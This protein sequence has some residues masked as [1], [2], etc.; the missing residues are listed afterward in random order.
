MS[1]AQLFNHASRGR[2]VGEVAAGYP[3]YAGV[4]EAVFDNGLGGLGGEAAPPVRFT[5]P[6]A[7]LR[8]PMIG[9]ERVAG[10]AGQFARMC[11]AKYLL[12]GF[13][14]INP[15]IRGVHRIRVWHAGRHAGDVPITTEYGDTGCV[16][17]C[18]LAQNEPVCS[19]FEA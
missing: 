16:R 6:V 17:R 12:A 7:N 8:A 4:P 9:C 15:L 1:K 19:D 10:D 14:I 2:V 13:E 18:Q 5:D 11:N 3:L